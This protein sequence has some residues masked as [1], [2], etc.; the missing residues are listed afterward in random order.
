MPRSCR[1]ARIWAAILRRRAAR[2]GLMRDG[3]SDSR[4]GPIVTTYRMWKGILGLNMSA[5]QIRMQFYC[6]T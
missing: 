3:R 1:G 6:A 2:P 4:F 5:M